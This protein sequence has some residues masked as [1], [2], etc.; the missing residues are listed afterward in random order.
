[1]KS[2]LPFFLRTACVAGGVALWFWTQKLISQKAAPSGGTV[3]DRLHEWTRPMNAWLAA[4]T[5]AANLLMIVTSAL[6]DLG[7]LY[8]LGRALLGPTMQPFLAI[9]FVFALR[10]ACQATVSLPA[11]PGIIWRRPGFPSLFVTYGVANDFFF[12]GH[13]AISV[14]IALHLAHTGSPGWAAAGAGLVGVEALAVIVLRAHY[15]MDIVAAL[16]AAWA[17]DRLASA[18]APL[19]DHG[20]RTL[21]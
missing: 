19:L 1:M 14:L 10:Q 5:G 2:L 17:G 21:G 12:S 16:F 8:L 13:T 6:I 15:T 18:V 4:R 7:G 9:L 20:L 3:G 11:P